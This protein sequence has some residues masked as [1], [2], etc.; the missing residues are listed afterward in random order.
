MKKIIMAALIFLAPSLAWTEGMDLRRDKNPE[1][2]TVGIGE[3]S[4]DGEL[5]LK[6]EGAYSSI[7]M[8]AYY[9]GAAHNYIWTRATRGTEASPTTLSNNDNILD[10]Y[11]D[12]WDTTGSDWDTAAAILFEIDG[13]PND[14]ANDMPGRI[15]FWTTPDGSATPAERMRID[16]A[17]RVIVSDDMENM[18]KIAGY[19]LSVGDEVATTGLLMESANAAENH[20]YLLVRAARGG[21][22]TGLA[23]LNNGDS[24]WNLWGYAHDGD[25]WHD[26]CS[27]QFRA[28]GAQ[29]DD[30]VPSRITF[31]TTP[32][33]SA[34]PA[35]RMRIEST[36][37]VGIGTSAPSGRLHVR[38]DANGSALMEVQ[39]DT[40]GTSAAAVARVTSN[41]SGGQ[42]AAYDDGYTGVAAYAD[43]V[44]LSSGS[45][46]A[47]LRIIS[48]ADGA[49]IV[50]GVGGAA[51]GDECLRMTDALGDPPTRACYMRTWADDDMDDE[52]TVALP[53]AITGHGTLVA[54]GASKESCEFFCVV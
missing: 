54:E 25:E 17:G 48:G 41:S 50:F 20:N 33:G 32:D 1:F 4:P 37:D 21:D 27:I 5:H 13:T 24:I 42:L 52:E 43:N 53:D 7:Y 14:A 47:A 8:D 30:D 22:W 38:E 40:A 44:V 26:T 34:T 2:D 11:G 15:T 9:T 46:A 45:S 3:D 51:A 31:H 16:N 6:D 35:E 39:N 49:P 10:L 23:A 18:P 29:G 28:D 19:E 36:G 12:G